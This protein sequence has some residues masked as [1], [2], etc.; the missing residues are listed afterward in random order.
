MPSFSLTP[1]D[2][3]PPAATPFPGGTQFQDEQVNVGPPE[4]KYVN[5][6]GPGVQA[7]YDNSAGRVNVFVSQSGGTQF[8]D[9]GVNRGGPAPSFVN[10][11]GAGVTATYTPSSDTVV[12]NIPGGGGGGGGTPVMSAKRLG[13]SQKTGSNLIYNTVS[14]FNTTLGSYS[15]STGEFTALQDGLFSFSAS[16]ILTFEFAPGS[17]NATFYLGVGI[18]DQALDRSFIYSMNQLNDLYTSQST[19]SLGASV[20]ANIPLSAG[21]K[22]IAAILNRSSFG[23]EFTRVAFSNVFYF[24]SGDPILNLNSVSIP[25]FS[26]IYYPL[27]PGEW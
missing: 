21:K 19:Q 13:T 24:M 7:T 1:L 11:T 14:M 2:P 15:T 3:F 18:Y 10:F 20:Y 27:P 5:F 12:V 16:C 22:V 26:V 17:S 23:P 4:P 25:T 9:E 8:Q 6:T